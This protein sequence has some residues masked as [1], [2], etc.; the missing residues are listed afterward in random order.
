MKRWIVYPAFLAI[1][2]LLPGGQGTD[3][4]KLQP[5]QILYIYMED[6]AVT[7]K[8][9]TGSSGS[10]W[11]L[12]DALTNMK[13]TA[14]G[15]LFLDTVAYL[16]ITEETKNLLSE[17]VGILRPGTEVAL[18]TAPMEPEELAPF[19]RVHNPCKKLYT[20]MAEQTDLPK[21]MKAGARWYLVQ[22]SN[23]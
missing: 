8:T 9:D 7:A 14:D 2:F 4:G 17:M 5:A 15:E 13:E 1:L 10:G 16:L 23:E 22:Q 20:C 3:V 11:N 6:G 21:L 19:L 12:K 18:V